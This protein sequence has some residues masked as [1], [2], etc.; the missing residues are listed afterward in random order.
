MYAIKLEGK[1][2]SDNR[3]IIKF[4][5]AEIRRYSVRW[6]MAPL[7]VQKLLL[8]VLQRSIKTCMFN[9]FGG[10][11]IVSMGGFASVIIV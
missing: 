4:V 2:R 6:Y 9:F 3:P 7:H 1:P 10:L 11:L 8:I 5:S